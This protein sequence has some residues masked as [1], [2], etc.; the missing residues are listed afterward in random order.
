MTP[1]RCADAALLIIDM[2]SD[3]QFEDADKL[4]PAACDMAANIRT[5]K[6]RCKAAGMP[7]LYANDNHGRWRSDFQK[8]IREAEQSHREAACIGKLLKPDDDDYLVLKPRHSAFVATPLHLLLNELRIHK[9]VLT[10]VTTD[11]CVLITATEAR[12]HDFEVWCPQDCV[13]TLTDERQQRI[14]AHMQEVLKICT[15]A[16]A[17]LRLPL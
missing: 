17:T 8:H 15:Q 10:G 1:S 16:S 11:Q 12:M 7:V 14:L 2:I 5:F 4:L 9:L 13:I 6:Q 3:W